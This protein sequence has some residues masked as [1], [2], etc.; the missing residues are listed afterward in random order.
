MRRFVGFVVNAALWKGAISSQILVRF[1]EVVDKTK[2]EH[3]MQKRWK[4][5]EI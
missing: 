4:P 2:G 3:Y 5:A 1:F